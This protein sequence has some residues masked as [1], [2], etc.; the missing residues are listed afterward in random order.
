MT[1]HEQEVIDIFQQCTVEL[2]A[3]MS[4]PN[5]VRFINLEMFKIAAEK[6]MNKAYYYGIKEGMREAADIVEH[7][8]TR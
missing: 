1:S 6:L 8:E 7:I 4:N 2:P 5:N 3:S